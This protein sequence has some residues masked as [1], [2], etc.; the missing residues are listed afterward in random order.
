[1]VFEGNFKDDQRQGFGKAK[2]TSLEAMVEYEGDFT[3]D[4]RCGKCDLL[5]VSDVSGKQTLFKF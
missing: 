5:K 3:D 2:Y 4:R 1:M